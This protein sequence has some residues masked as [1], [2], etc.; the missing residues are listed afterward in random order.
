MNRLIIKCWNPQQAHQEITKTVWPWLKS[1]LMAGHEII[2]ELRIKT[3]SLEQN[4]LMWAM[5]T[6]I[7]SQV[8]WY[9][10]KLSPEDWKHIF[11]A[12][13]RKQR[14]VPGLD[15]QIVVLGQSTSKMTVKEMSDLIELMNAFASER[16]IQFKGDMQYVETSE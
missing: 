13:L 2:I 14:A 9:G 4:S 16:E 6:D 11:T 7:S 8:N 3:R 5:L 1:M 15:G 10:H 12:S